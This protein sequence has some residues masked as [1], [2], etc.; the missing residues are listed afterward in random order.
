MAHDECPY[1]LPQEDVDNLPAGLV[2][3]VV[4]PRIPPEGQGLYAA[5]GPLPVALHGGGLQRGEGFVVPLVDGLQLSAVED[6]GLPATGVH[7]RGEVP[8]PEV[9]GGVLP[10]VEAWVGHF[11]V[12]I[13]DFNVKPLAP[14]AGVDSHLLEPLQLLPVPLPLWDGNPHGLRED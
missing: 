9:D 13:D 4:Y 10:H 12:E 2:E 1:P 3:E 6:N 7:H 14:E 8:H 11:L 5:G